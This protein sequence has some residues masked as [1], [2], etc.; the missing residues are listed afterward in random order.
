MC[1]LLP[2]CRPGVFFNEM[3]M[4]FYGGTPLAY[5]CCFDL[6]EC[7]QQMLESGLVSL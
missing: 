3:P 4:R 1:P 7:V 2:P 6:R 5:A